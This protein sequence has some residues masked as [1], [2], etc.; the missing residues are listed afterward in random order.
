MHS[1]LGTDKATIEKTVK[2]YADPV[3]HGTWDDA[4]KMNRLQRWEMQSLTRD[5]LVKYMDYVS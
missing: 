5:I 3:R 1:A 4:K 2:N